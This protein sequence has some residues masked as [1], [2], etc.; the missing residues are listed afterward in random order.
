M[1]QPLP[2]DQRSGSAA[3]V[4]TE[5]P[6]PCTPRSQPQNDHDDEKK[7]KYS[8]YDT[9]RQQPLRQLGQSGT[10]SNMEHPQQSPNRPQTLNSGLQHVEGGVVAA[11]FQELPA[12][13]LGRVGNR[14]GIKEGAVQNGDCMQTRFKYKLKLGL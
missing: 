5:K 13:Q 2:T 12:S 6:R 9:T 4:P 10:G 7:H 1:G 3:A 14:G 8:D 11:L